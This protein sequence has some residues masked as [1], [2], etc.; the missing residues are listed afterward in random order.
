MVKKQNQRGPNTLAHEYI[1]YIIHNPT[2]GEIA[3]QTQFRIRE[4][5]FVIY[6]FPLDQIS[7]PNSR[8]L[9]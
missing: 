3:D 7:S 5:Y 2:G 4:T 6:L 8:N 9:L 1:A